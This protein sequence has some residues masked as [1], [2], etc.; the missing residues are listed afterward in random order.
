MVEE[1]W[2]NS[3]ILAF[4]IQCNQGAWYSHPHTSHD[5]VVERS[6]HLGCCTW[7]R[8]MELEQGTNLKVDEI[9][10]P[11]FGILP[12]WLLPAI[13]SFW[14]LTSFGLYFH[15][16]SRTDPLEMM[17]KTKKF[18]WNFEAW[19]SRDP[20]WNL[21]ESILSHCRFPSEKMLVFFEEVTP[22]HSFSKHWKTW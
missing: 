20:V 15:D 16:F 13:T 11:K 12:S 9:M 14:F 2:Y 5:V 6:Q 17:L 3:S 21:S 18:Q 19:G 4:F 10:M 7:I 22:Q 1:F 8:M